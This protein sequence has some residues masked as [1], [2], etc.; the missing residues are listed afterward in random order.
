M[1]ESKDPYKLITAERLTTSH[2]GTAAPGCPAEQRSAISLSAR[3]S[4]ASLD[5]TA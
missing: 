1:A 2:V 5:R 4:R 3:G